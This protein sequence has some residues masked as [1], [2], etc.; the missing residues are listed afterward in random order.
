MFEFKHLRVYTKSYLLTVA[1][2]M[3]ACVM[4]NVQNVEKKREKAPTTKSIVSNEIHFIFERKSD[5]EKKKLQVFV[6]AQGVNFI[7][8]FLNLL[9]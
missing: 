6:A 5:K 4:N 3:R 1:R 7:S 9:I 2:G 8:L